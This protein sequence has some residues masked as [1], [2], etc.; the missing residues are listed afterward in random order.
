[1]GLHSL[2]PTSREP[3]SGPQDRHHGT[4]QVPHQASYGVVESMT[5]EGGIYYQSDT[6]VGSSGAPI[7]DNVGRLVGIHAHGGAESNGGCLLVNVVAHA[8][9]RRSLKEEILQRAGAGYDASN[10]DHVAVVAYLASTLAAL[11]EVRTFFF[12]PLRALFRPRLV[13]RPCSY[14]SRLFLLTQRARRIVGG[15]R[16]TRPSC[17]L[18]RLC[19]PVRSSGCTRRHSTRTA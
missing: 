2:G 17:N 1:M 9:S 12:S 3:P 18:T 19:R 6:E 11:P 15:A 16:R 13:P 5:D 4:P 14:S 10:P 7:F 8:K